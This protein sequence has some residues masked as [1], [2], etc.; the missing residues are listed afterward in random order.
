MKRAS[1]CK[2]REKRRNLRG[3]MI[4]CGRN[5]VRSLTFLVEEAIALYDSSL[6]TRDSPAFPGRLLQTGITLARPSTTIMDGRF[7]KA[8]MPSLVSRA[9]PPPGDG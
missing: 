8:L 4:P 3:S 2:T 6:S 9:G 1:A 7:R 5:L